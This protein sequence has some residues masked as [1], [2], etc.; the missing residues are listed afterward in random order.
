MI[1]VTVANGHLGG[2]VIEGANTRDRGGRSTCGGR[3]HL[4]GPTLQSRA[5]SSRHGSQE[6]IGR[7]ITCRLRGCGDMTPIWTENV[8]TVVVAPTQKTSS[9]PARAAL[10]KLTRRCPKRTLDK[11][12]T[13]T[14]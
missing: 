10:T 2:F 3:A 14:D 1:A 11:V 7:G 6:S 8:D 4:S 12:L 9:R 13:W 5:A